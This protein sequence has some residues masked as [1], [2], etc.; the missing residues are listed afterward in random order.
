MSSSAIPPQDQK[1]QVLSSQASNQQPSIYF[2]SESGLQQDTV[3]IARSLN[4]KLEMKVSLMKDY[5]DVYGRSSVYVSDIKNINQLNLYHIIS[6][7][8]D[9]NLKTQDYK[10]VLLIIFSMRNRDIRPFHRKQW[11]FK[12]QRCVKQLLARPFLSLPDYSPGP[13]Q[14]QKHS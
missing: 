3:D 8:L 7:N 10:C 2:I 13:L 9:F 4:L 12:P 5:D 11:F 1:L 6:T 14:D